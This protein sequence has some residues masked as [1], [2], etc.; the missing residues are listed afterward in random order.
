M[1]KTTRWYTFEM[2]NYAFWVLPTLRKEV[3]MMVIKT[4]KDKP[5]GLSAEMLYNAVMH[6]FEELSQDNCVTV[7]YN[8]Y[9][10]TRGESLE[11][12]YHTLLSG[13]IF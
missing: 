7:K 9:I 12:F 4:P 6:V 10:F 5:A 8:N 3:K 11:S 13:L 1:K 2:D